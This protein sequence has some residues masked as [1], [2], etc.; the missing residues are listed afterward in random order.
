MHTIV[1]DSVQ[2]VK[3]DFEN[4]HMMVGF[5]A[6][7][8]SKKENPKPNIGRYGVESSLPSPKGEH[9]DSTFTQVNKLVRDQERIDRYKEKMTYLESAV[10]LLEDERER[11]L[12]EG[13]LDKVPVWEVAQVM[14]CSR[15]TAHE[16]KRSMLV[17]LAVM[18][19]PDEAV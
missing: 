13:M 19:Y 12:A 9:G 8:E 1:T 11:L 15:K 3:K 6:E 4:Y 5:V 2:K 10:A 17:N 18:M 16:L 14:S 7:I